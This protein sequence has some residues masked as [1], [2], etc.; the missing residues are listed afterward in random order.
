MPSG[1]NEAFA[2]VKALVA[3]FRANE[4]FYISPAYQE[5]EARRDF[6]DKFWFALG[7]D[8]NHERQ[9]NP[10]EQEVKV[11]RREYGSSQRRADYAFYLAPNFRDVKFYVEAKKPH[12]D[13]ATAD[14]YFQTIR[15]GWSSSTPVAVLH[16]FEQFQILD[17]RYRPN[18]DTA[19]AQNIQKFHFIQYEN[20]DRFAEIYW[21][22]S[23]EAVASGSLEK[24]AETLPKKR[25][26]AVQRGL[27][28]GAWHKIDDSF[29][30]ELDE[31]RDELARAFKV[32]NP[33]LDGEI[34]TELTQRTLDRLVFLRFL[35]DKH[36]EPQNRIAY[37]GD[38]GTA[39]QDFIAESRRLDGIYNG[40]VYKKH[41]ILDSP[42]FKLEDDVF[43]GICERLSHLN[44]PYDFNAIP[45]HI[46]GS[47]Y[48]RFLGKVIVSTNKRARVEEKPEVR[49]AGGVYYTPEYIVRYIVENTVGKLIAGKTPAQ[50]TEMR[51]ADIAC[52]SGS[53]LL[54]VY[55]LLIRHH[56]AY[57]N[58]NAGKAKKGDVVERDDG[59]HL[60]LQKKREILLSSIYGVDIDPQ[61]VE[62]AQL[63]LYLKLLQDETPASARHHQLEF[64]ETLLPSLNKNIVC[65]NSLIGTDI[66]SGQLFAS[67][68]ERKLNPMDFE[69]RFPHIFE[70]A[71]GELRETALPLDFSFPGVPLHG[72]FSYTKKRAS[73]PKP[74][75][76]PIPESK[77]GFDA[78]VGNPPYGAETSL[79]TIEYLRA[80]YPTLANSLD[81]FIAFV[82]RA[83]ILLKPKGCLGYIIP[84]GWVSTPSCRKLRKLFVSSFRP[85]SFVSL[86]YDVFEGAYIDAMIITA[87]KSDNDPAWHGKGDAAVDLFVFPVRQKIRDLQDFAQVKKIGDFGHWYTGEDSEFLVT[88]SADEA[89]LVSKL[90]NHPQSLNDYVDIMR[91]MEEFHPRASTGMKKPVRAFNGELRRYS[92]TLGD[93]A[94][95]DYTKAVEAA[96]PACFFHD[97][98]ILLRQLLSRK[99][100]LQAVW[101]DQI[102]LT[103]QSIQSLIRK[104]ESTIDLK[105]VLAILNS[106]LLSWFFCQ[107][108]M[109]ARRDDFPKTIIK[110]TRELPFPDN[111]T[112]VAEG[113][114][115]DLVEQMLASKKQL[116][117]SQTD[118]DKD[119][120]NNRCD[121]LDRQIDAVVYELYGLTPGEIEIVE[122]INT[123]NS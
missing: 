122:R 75:P 44:S 54:G 81:T 23:R 55:D 96:K 4:K 27:L 109:V 16:D 11:E 105:C 91:G 104:A 86:P 63:S 74:P 82:E 42:G 49:K 35:E 76:I 121:G 65:G 29:L 8:V 110:Q 24:F 92:F 36:I 71:S 20:P 120:Y 93:R 2:N 34:L 38:N 41:G 90:R 83:A 5:Q 18:I 57:Y 88:A 43:S 80:H 6:I 103:N 45:I 50:V 84:S 79:R 46:L 119:F 66:L 32:S 72:A 99:F 118:K 77:R 59:L 112:L 107:I 1:Y 101:T 87:K 31:F 100:R 111:I 21:L 30:E 13:I 37:F 73:K 33:K 102:F 25:G 114:L 117:A 60:S 69:Q 51:F 61:A 22:F 78:I 56:T 70:T 52:G 17:C 106:R 123:M 94:F 89:E 3:D 58:Q 108:N 68:E 85:E 62:V 28:R 7:W 115:V 48:E 15:Y 95:E 40:I 12:G 53:F 19:L 47:I 14:N 98:R 9:K 26:K 113:R 97:E 116:A 67:D 39:W 64:H 10:F